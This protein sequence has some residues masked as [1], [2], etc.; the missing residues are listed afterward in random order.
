MGYLFLMI[1]AVFAIWKGHL[2]LVAILQK[3]FPDIIFRIDTD[4]QI[5]ALSIDDSPHHEVTPKI[6]NVLREQDV[7]ATFFV[8][9]EYIVNNRDLL[10]NIILEGHEIGNHMMKDRPAIGLSVEKFEKDLLETDNLLTPYQ[11]PILFRPGSGLISKKQIRIIKKAGYSCCLGDLYFND[12][13]VT[14]VWLISWLIL[15]CLRPGSIIILHDGKSERI[16]TVKILQKILPKI[17]SRGYRITTVS[18]LIGHKTKAGV[19]A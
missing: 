9:G 13:R 8:I 1:A 2:L 16:R 18:D 4:E 19:D 12:P 11:K 17:I 15:H 6:L 7:K 3:V 14:S 5:V 10:T